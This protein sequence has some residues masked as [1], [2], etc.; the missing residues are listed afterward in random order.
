MFD[1]IKNY[2]IKLPKMIQVK[3]KFPK[4]SIENIKEHLVRQISQEK[5][6]SKIKPGI[7]IAIGVGS[8]GISRELEIV[9]ILVE[10]LK[11][12][13]VKPFIVPA[14]GSHGGA[15]SQGQVAILA[16]YGITE[17]ELGIPIKSSMETIEIGE[18]KDGVPIYIQKDAYLAD[19]IIPVNKINV[20]GDFRGEI[21]SGMLKMLVIGFGKH[22]GA[23]FVHSLGA[24][25]FHVIIPQVGSIILEKLPVIFG[26]ACLEDAFHNLAELNLVLPEDM[27]SEEKRML[28]YVKENMARIKIPEIDVLIIEEIGKNISGDGLDVN[29][30]G[31]FIGKQ[32]ND[33]KSS[34]I[35]KILLLDLTQETE[36]NACG[37][38]N[39]DIITKKLFDKIDF[40]KTYTNAITSGVLESVQIPL[41]AKN[42]QEAIELATYITNVFD[43]TKAKIVRIQNTNKLEEIIVS[44]SLYH[45]ITCQEEDFDVVG[46]LHDISFDQKGNLM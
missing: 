23:T 45:T 35:K 39:G 16:S 18:T 6:L 43:A 19:G 32:K 33:I 31:R 37:V 4:H 5:I 14:M 38:G 3:Q 9:K 20:H 25:N 1:F 11:V 13:G 7:S 26:V 36:G 10:Q 21:E 12:I 22:R 15:T 2:Q 24:E 41:V 27:I 17:E 28:K 30:V 29:V 8:R 34:L 44:E 42:D 40:N 46:S